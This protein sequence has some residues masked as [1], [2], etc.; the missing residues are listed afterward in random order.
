M[1]CF[2]LTSYPVRSKI[3]DRIL[4]L[5]SGL[6]LWVQPRE[7]IFDCKRSDHDRLGGGCRGY[8]HAKWDWN[9]N[10]S[11]LTLQSLSCG[12]KGGR[13]SAGGDERSER[14]TVQW[15]QL[16]ATKRR[17]SCSK[18]AK[19]F[20]HLQG[21]IEGLALSLSKGC[22]RNRPRLWAGAYTDRWMWPINFKG[23]RADSVCQIGCF[24]S[25]EKKRWQ[26]RP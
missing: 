8:P 22:E 2:G 21:A 25:P 24:F 18:S 19:L 15:R 5:S 12:E 1:S 4:S 20:D 7:Q 14:V 26:K 11:G 3:L 9:I 17:T 16:N 23:H 10:H 13:F 6:T